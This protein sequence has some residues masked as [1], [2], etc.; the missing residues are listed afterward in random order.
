VSTTELKRA[1]N[2]AYQ[3]CEQLQAAMDRGEISEQDW[4][5]QN[6][7]YFTGIYM[8][9]GNPRAQSGHGGDEERFRYSQGMILEALN[10]SGSFIDIGCANGYLAEKLSQWTQNLEIR[11]DFHGLDFSHELLELAARRIPASANK[12]FLGNALYWQPPRQFDYVCIR[13]LSYVPRDKQRMLFF[14]LYDDILAANGRLI[15]G[16]AAEITD[17]SGIVSRIQEWGISPSGYCVKSHQE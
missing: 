10:R 4:F 3:F 16:P 17:E 7:R 8:K 6:N 5:D 9:A 13:E 14:H 12:L 2:G 15:L 11:I 1:M